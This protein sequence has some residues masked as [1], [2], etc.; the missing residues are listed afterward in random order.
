[1]SRLS[2][3]TLILKTLQISSARQFKKEKMFWFIALQESLDQQV[4]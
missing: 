4:L 2:A 3:L 1:M